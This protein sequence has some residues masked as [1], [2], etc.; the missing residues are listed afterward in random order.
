VKRGL[1]IIP[2]ST[3]DELLRNALVT[4]PQP[5]EWSEPEEPAVA[6]RVPEAKEEVIRH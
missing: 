4:P 6:A 2:I 3:I 1:K 5:I